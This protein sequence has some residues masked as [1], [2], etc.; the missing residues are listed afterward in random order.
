MLSKIVKCGCAKLISLMLWLTIA[1]TTSNAD[2][3]VLPVSD[4]HSPA[5]MSALADTDITLDLNKIN[6]TGYF[7][8]AGEFN[9]IT[10]GLHNSASRNLALS[11]IGFDVDSKIEVEIHINGHLLGHLTVGLNNGINAGDTFLI[12]RSLLINGVNIIEFVQT[13][14]DDKWGIYEIIIQTQKQHRAKNSW[15]GLPTVSDSAWDDHA[16]RSVLNVFAFGGHATDFRIATWANMRPQAAIV[17]MLNFAEHNHKLSPIS[18]DEVYTEPTYKYGKLWNFAEHYLSSNRSN[19]PI[20]KNTKDRQSRSQFSLDSWNFAGL[21]TLMVTTRG[22]NPF[23]QRI[24]FW[25]TNYH[26]AVNLNTEV[27]PHQL[28]KYYDDILEALENNQPYQNVIAK[29][30]ASAAVASQYK[31]RYNKWNA[32]K[33]ECDC[34]EDF[35]REI[36]Q[37]FFGIL[38]KRDPLGLEHHENI[39]IKNTAKALTDMNADKDDLLGRLPEVVTFGTEYHYPGHLTLDILNTPIPGSN[40][41]QRINK[42]A[43][44]AINHPES[45]ENLPII[46]ISGLADENLSDSK[47]QLLREAWG[48]MPSKQLLTFIR[49]YAVSTLFHD[50]SRI[51]YWNSFERQLLIANKLIHNNTEGLAA[52]YLYN[53]IASWSHGIDTEGVAFFR[54]IRNVFGGQT[55]LEASDSAVVFENNYNRYTETY[56]QITRHSYDKLPNWEKNWAQVLPKTKNGNFIVKDVA[57]WLW[58]HFLN[59]DLKNFGPLEQAHLYALLSSNRDFPLLMCLRQKRLEEGLNNNT[60]KTLE[61][62]ESSRCVSKNNRFSQAELNLLQGIYSTSDV[63]TTPV[64]AWLDELSTRKLDLFSND[65]NQRK[66]HTEKIGAAINFILATQ[67]IFAQQGY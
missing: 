21:W 8:N 44:V 36:H 42:I 33:N 30:S 64:Q 29:A 12:N 14:I 41:K 1:M 19:L 54:P 26:M 37:L 43:Q 47:K 45:L 3:S 18:K 55:A 6:T 22:L 57:R 48:R 31:H 15:L 32:V 46:I 53:P 50:E 56:W 52:L 9:R 23:R 35:A 17:E 2:N 27:N 28:A 62:D 25:E 34:N 58:R 7:S 63:Q 13:N 60:L 38:G 65:F 10:A 11:L 40:A 67:Y 51:K 49:A 4:S 16:V 20:P 66:L 5:S 59:D 24:G 39:T 61:A